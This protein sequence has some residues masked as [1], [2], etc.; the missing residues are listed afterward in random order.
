LHMVPAIGSSEKIIT[1]NNSESQSYGG[2]P[3]LPVTNINTNNIKTS[4]DDN[5]LDLPKPIHSYQA[6]ILFKQGIIRDTLRGTITSSANRESPS[7]VG[8]GV[9][10]PGRPIYS[11]G[12]D[13]SSI[14]QA[15]LAGNDESLK[16]ISRRG[17]HSIVL[18]DGDLIGR[19][20]LVRIRSSAGHQIMMSDDGQTIF[21]IHSNGQSWI[22]LGKEGT[23]DMFNT[24]SFNVRTQG[25]INLHADNNINIHAKKKLN[26]K[27]EDIYIQSEKSTSHNVG[28]DYKIQTSG[29]YSHKIS[30]T[31]SLQSGGTGSIQSSGVLY[32]MQYHHY[33]TLHIQIR[34]LIVLK[35]T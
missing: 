26:I 28:S 16:V 29:K 30:G 8:W 20:N 3:I 24:N 12:Y 17:G 18:D 6:S 32:I 21:I 11:G 34:C 22:E 27:A 4:D 5:F 25:D 19:D 35:V 33:K 13:D 23:I 1:N 2:A 14:G 7:R 9:S 31:M 15:A 10:T